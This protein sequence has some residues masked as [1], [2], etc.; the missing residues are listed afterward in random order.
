MFVLYIKT[1][2]APSGW[3]VPPERGTSEAEGVSGLESLLSM[4]GGFTFGEETP[5]PL[6]GTPLFRWE[7]PC[8]VRGVGGVGC[9]DVS[10]SFI[11]VTM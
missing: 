7:S 2:S 1:L 8:G 3:T 10:V 5:S 9:F 6:W 11:L 4:R